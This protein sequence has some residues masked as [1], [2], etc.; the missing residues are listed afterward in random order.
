MLALYYSVQ[1]RLLNPPLNG[2]RSKL[3][4]ALLSQ[5]HYG[6]PYIVTRHRLGVLLVFSS[7]PEAV[8]DIIFIGGN[9]EL[10]D[11]EAHAGSEIAGK[12][13]T[14]ASHISKS[15]APIK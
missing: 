5:P 3:P 11:R 4:S 12:N 1:R 8:Q 10:L 2:T 13:V 15:K 9:D 6:T 7:L 14:L